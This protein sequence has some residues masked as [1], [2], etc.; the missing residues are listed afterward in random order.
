[1]E[2]LSDSQAKALRELQG[3]LSE[4]T[5]ANEVSKLVVAILVG[6]VCRFSDKP[7]LRKVLYVMFFH[8]PI[9]LVEVNNQTLSAFLSYLTV[10]C[11]VWLANRSF[12]S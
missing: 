1:M 4:E 11:K 9:L 10:Y 5:S 6:Y 12:D 3:M 8:L 2:D 7:E